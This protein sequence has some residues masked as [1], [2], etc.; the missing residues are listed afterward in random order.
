MV[1]IR[2]SRTGAKKKPSY[3]VVVMDKRRARDSRNIEIV[4]HYNPRPDPIELVLKRDRIDYW[5]S[6]GAQPSATVQRLVRYY[7]EKVVP[8]QVEEEDTPTEAAEAAP[9]AAATPE[10]EPEVPAQPGAPVEADTAEEADD[11]L[12]EQIEAALA[13]DAAGGMPAAPPESIEEPETDE[14]LTVEA[15]PADGPETK[16]EA[17]P[18]SDDA[19]KD[20]AKADSEAASE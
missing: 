4:G 19:P 5:L 12:D 7:D 15:A 2:L 11:A 10:V 6:V 17:E 1:A 14:D 16:A 3:R 20:N 9:A 13:E 8:F 18:A